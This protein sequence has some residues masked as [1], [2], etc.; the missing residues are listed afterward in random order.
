[1]KKLIVVS[2][3]FQLLAAAGVALLIY[4]AEP[5]RVGG[6]SHPG[7]PHTFQEDVLRTSERL[8][9]ALAKVRWGILTMMG[10]SVLA[11]I[12]SLV[13]RSNPKAG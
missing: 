3:V 8:E 9:A 1:M 4:T 11:Q 2:L 10:V 7:T 5:S 13:L 12:G 6:S